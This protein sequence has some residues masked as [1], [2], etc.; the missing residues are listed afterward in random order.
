[1]VSITEDGYNVHLQFTP[2]LANDWKNAMLA[3][4][5]LAVGNYHYLTRRVLDSMNASQ[6]ESKL[7]L[8]QTLEKFDVQPKR[9]A[10]LAG[11]FAQYIVPLMFD[12]FPECEW[13]ENFEIDHDVVPISYKFNKRYK[14]NNKYKLNMRNVMIKPLRF[15]QNPNTATPKE[16]LFDVVINCA[17]EHMYP[18]WKWRELNAPIQKNPLLVLQSSNDD[19]HEDH[20]N[21][22]QSEEELIDQARIKHVIYSGARI[23]PNKSTRFMVIGR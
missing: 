14:D 15:K 17:C 22:V 10:L 16:D 8:V 20:I 1:M 9:V 7:W 6:L 2:D 19:I 18:M 5:E 4:S 13:I 23:L 12:T 11:W 21:C 3:S